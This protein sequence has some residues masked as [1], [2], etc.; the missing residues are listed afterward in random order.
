MLV[1]TQ[2]KCS[3]FS[4]SKLNGSFI[5]P[6]CKYTKWYWNIIEKRLSEE[7]VGYF[8]RHHIIPKF[9]G[10]SNS[11]N[12]LVKVT[13]RE[14]YILHLLLVRICKK[15]NDNKM[16]AKSVSSVF[17][18]IMGPN[19][20]KNMIKISSKNIE[21]IK[22]EHM[23]K[24]KELQSG[25]NNSFYG[26]KHSKKSKI[27]M[28]LKHK[29]EKHHMYG[30]SHSI[31]TKEKMSKAKKGKPLTE[32]HRSKLGLKGKLNHNYGKSLSEEIKQKMKDSHWLNNGGTHPML[33]NSHKEE[34]VEKMRINSTKQW[35]DAHSP[36]G[37]YFHKVSLNEMVRKHNLNAD[38]IRRFKNI[39]V[40]EIPERVKSQ[41]KESRL[42]TTGWLFI[43]L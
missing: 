27:K 4:G 23:L 18:F 36:D 28:S 24:M 42:N 9:M 35:W 32:E 16:Y 40:P 8:E 22:K 12:N 11:K 26:K 37:K 6:E 30:K 25:K 41:T 31:Q 10:G 33:G 38:C 7:P 21:L 19:C 15:S 43:L 14:H 39:I 2:S 17:C 29:G 5:F 3:E 20:R 1:S 34:S 13:G